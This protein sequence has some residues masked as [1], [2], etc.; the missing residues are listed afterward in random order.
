MVSNRWDSWAST[1]A[2]QRDSDLLTFVG[3][4]EVSK[5]AIVKVLQGFVGDREAWVETVVGPRGMFS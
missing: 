1:S 2:R 5:V 4:T 3:R